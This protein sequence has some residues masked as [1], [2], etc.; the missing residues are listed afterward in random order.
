MDSP[1]SDLKVP[2]GSN[3][4]AS[5]LDTPAAIGF[6]NILNTPATVLVPFIITTIP[7]V[8]DRSSFNCS[9]AGLVFA[10]SSTLDPR[11]SVIKSPFESNSPNI[12]ACSIVKLLFIAWFTLQALIGA[13]NALTCLDIS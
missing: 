4:Y 5:P 13:C 1:V 11:V 8:F 3:L 9:D 7:R 2:G 10:F 12:A 6:F